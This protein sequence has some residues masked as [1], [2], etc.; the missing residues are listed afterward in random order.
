[1]NFF[2][3]LRPTL[4]TSFSLVSRE[5]ASNTVKTPFNSTKHFQPSSVGVTKAN[6]HLKVELTDHSGRPLGKMSLREA[7]EKA[8]SV[9]LK[10]VI[11]SEETDPPQFKLMTGK[12]LFKLQME[13]KDEARDAKGLEQPK[14]KEITVNLGIEDHDLDIKL[15]MLKNFHEKGH[16]VKFVVTSRIMHKSEK[17]I[18]KLQEQFVERLGSLAPFA[19]FKEEK[20]TN[21]KVVLSVEPKN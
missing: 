21:N 18:P 5:Y 19:K 8:V 1:M 14:P 13:S 4:S 12:E 15:K 2:L 7:N 9:Q 17:N 16:P 20:K 10:L 11:L 3:K 6:R